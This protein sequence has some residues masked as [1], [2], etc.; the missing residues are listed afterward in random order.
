MS[1]ILNAEGVTLSHK[2][3]S[4]TRNMKMFYTELAENLGA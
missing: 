3:G 2:T 4:V 1:P